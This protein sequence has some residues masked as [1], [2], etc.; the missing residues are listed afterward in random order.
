MTIECGAVNTWTRLA[1][2]EYLYDGLYDTRA[3]GRGK[4]SGAG[5]ATPLRNCKV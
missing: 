2:S 4:G 3:L 1:Y 5:E